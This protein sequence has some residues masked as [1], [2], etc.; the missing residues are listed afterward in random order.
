M[1]EQTGTFLAEK[2]AHP[3]DKR[4]RFVEEGHIYYVD[5]NPDTHTS[6]TTVIHLFAQLFD[7]D[8]VI[9]K[10][11]RSSKWPE[12]K[13]YGKTVEEIKQ[14]WSKTGKEASDAG[15]KLHLEIELFFDQLASSGLI[16]EHPEPTKEFGYF[17]DFYDKI[18]KNSLTPYRTEWYVFDEDI[19]VCGSID[20]VFCD[21]D[22]PNIL[23]IYDWKRSKEIKKANP[24]QTMLFPLHYFPDC[25]YSHYSLQLNLYRRILQA[26][27]DKKV[28]SLRLIILHPDKTGFEIEEVPI[29]GDDIMNR[30]LNAYRKKKH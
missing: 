13:Y 23:H 21:P 10:M 26:K 24:W 9:R 20:M 22:N 11:M 28:I 29:L 14:E 25:N 3:R 8:S 2:N 18:I 1:P 27:Y 12:N 30:L 5:G 4:I 15:S 19:G 16:P 17:L 7:A 6:V